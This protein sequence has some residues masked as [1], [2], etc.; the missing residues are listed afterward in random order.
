MWEIL[1]F[2]DNTTGFCLESL[3]KHSVVT[4]EMCTIKSFFTILNR[5]LTKF[6]KKSNI[7]DHKNP[8]KCDESSGKQD[9]KSKKQ[10]W[11]RYVIKADIDSPNYWPT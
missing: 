7:T 8:I 9:P 5:T 11:K 3:D 6:D 4:A 1:Q 2:N 10:N